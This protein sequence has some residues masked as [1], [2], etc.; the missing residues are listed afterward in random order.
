[1]ATTSTARAKKPRDPQKVA[2]A[3]AAKA[4]VEQGYKGTL[5]ALKF[6]ENIIGFGNDP[7]KKDPGNV[8]DAL[9]AALQSSIPDSEVT[10]AF[11]RIHAMTR[12]PAAK[13]AF[14]SPT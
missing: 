11:M 1:M 7:V 8:L 12:S 6:A 10:H 5:A 4:A 9:A 14:D 3:A 13:S 2:A